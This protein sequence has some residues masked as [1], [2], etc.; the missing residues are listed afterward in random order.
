MKA[1]LSLVAAAISLF[2][3]APVLSSTHDDIIQSVKDGKADLSFRYRYEMVDQDGVAN[4]GNAS[5]LLT[6]LNYTTASVNGFSAMV[7]FD[8]VSVIG[9][10]N[11]NNSYNGKTDRAVVAD[12]SGTEVNQ[13]YLAY[14]QGGLTL[15]AGRQ[16]INLDDQRFVG[17]VAWRQNE[18]TFDGYRAQYQVNPQFT[19]D[20]SYVFN[21][22]RIFGEGSANSDF[23]GAT[24]L[25]NS[26][27]KVNDQHSVTGFA[28]LLDFDNGAAAS[29]ATYG[30]RYEGAQDVFSWVLSYANQT[31]YADNPNDYSADYVLAEVAAKLAGIK[32]S[33]GYEQLGS[34]DGKAFNTPLATAH[35]F[36]GFADKFLATPANG[37]QDWYVGVA[38][39]VAAVKWSATYHSFSSDIADVDYGTEL[40]LTAAYAMTSN[41][42]T[43]V[44]YAH[45]SADD[46]ATDTDKLW[47][48]V[49]VDFK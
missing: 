18:Q 35:K 8:D 16:R 22:N 37:I 47:L 12:P 36:Q 10:E 21:V 26:K 11:Y 5:T 38:G 14:K 45:F 32:W 4:N 2:I 40:D 29:S 43:L 23:H 44:K 17:G 3:S 41:C 19:V 39:Q 15:T 6:R 34:D 9:D 27:F 13:A 24:Q 20:Y 28:Y 25:L 7:E 1:K 33:L 49:S 46:F 31:D 30:V 48:M 42:K